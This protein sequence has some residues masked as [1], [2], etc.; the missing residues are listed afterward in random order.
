MSTVDQ[1]KRLLL[2]PEHVAANVRN[3]FERICSAIEAV[4]TGSLGLFNWMLDA[5]HE[6]RSREAAVIVRRHRQLISPAAQGI[7]R[8]ADVE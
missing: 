1:H 4:L 6:S 2:A 8:Q 3:L 7:R 5:L